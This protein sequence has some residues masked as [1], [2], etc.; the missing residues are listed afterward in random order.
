MPAKSQARQRA[1]G[2]A[3]W[4][5]DIRCTLG[6]SVLARDPWDGHRD[7]RQRVTEQMRS[8]LGPS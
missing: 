1:A 7:V 2:A 5:I 8:R 3:Q 6:S 4:T